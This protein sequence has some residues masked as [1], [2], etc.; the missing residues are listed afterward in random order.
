MNVSSQVY[1]IQFTLL[2]VNWQAIKIREVH[3]FLIQVDYS[4]FFSLRACILVVAQLAWTISRKRSTILFVARGRIGQRS[5]LG[6][7]SRK[8]ILHISPEK[9]PD[10]DL[11]V[12]THNARYIYTEITWSAPRFLGALLF[13]P[14]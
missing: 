7:V 4:S 6:R 8:Y 12:Y 2:F 13:I 3:K 14:N 10:I 5:D 9:A 11:Y 1:A